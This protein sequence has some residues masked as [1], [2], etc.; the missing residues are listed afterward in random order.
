MFANAPTVLA[1]FSNPNAA[2]NLGCVRQTASHRNAPPLDRPATSDHRRR[3]L[4]VCTPTPQDLHYFIIVSSI[5]AVPAWLFDWS[6]LCKSKLH[7]FSPHA[8]AAIQATDR[9]R[10]ARGGPLTIKFLT[11]C[12]APVSYQ[13]SYISRRPSIELAGIAREQP[14]AIA[15][16]N[17][18][19]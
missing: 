7:F 4:S 3:H 9:R 16:Y 15:R 10:A 8:A 5:G 18:A 13:I 14:G 2:H 19:V 12:D 11:E 6:V 17:V 1:A